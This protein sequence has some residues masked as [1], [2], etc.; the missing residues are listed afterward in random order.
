MTLLPV[1]S[2]QSLNLKQAAHLPNEI[3]RT[4]A[5]LIIYNFFWYSNMAENM[6]NQNVC[7]RTCLN[8]FRWYSF[9]QFHEV[10]SDK[11]YITISSSSFRKW[12]KEVNSDPLHQVVS[13]RG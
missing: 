13:S 1:R 7:C 8:V 4:N 10:I 12:T 11:Q 2:L 6:T 9:C 3:E 5:S